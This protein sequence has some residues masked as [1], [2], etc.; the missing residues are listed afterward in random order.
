MMCK[1]ERAYDLMVGHMP[2][3]VWCPYCGA[4]KNGKEAEWLL[5]YLAETEGG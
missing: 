2:G 1:H 3:V 4:V 5:P